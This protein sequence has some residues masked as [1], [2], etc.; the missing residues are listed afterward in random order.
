MIELVEAPRKLATGLAT[1]GGARYRP[2]SSPLGRT[3]DRQR[4]DR[5][6][7]RHP[8]P[9]WRLSLARSGF[10][11]LL[12]SVL[13]HFPDAAPPAGDRVSIFLSRRFGS[14]LLEIELSRPAF[15][16][17]PR[18]AR[19]G[20]RGRCRSRNPL[21]M[22]SEV[23]TRSRRVCCLIGPWVLEQSWRLDNVRDHVRRPKSIHPPRP[24][25]GARSIG[26]ATAATPANR[27]LG[28]SSTPRNAGSARPRTHARS[29]GRRADVLT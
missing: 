13:P 23:L 24:S 28:C 11:G 5:G 29:Q 9:R 16:S 17:A 14:K 26:A 19:S 10:R 7:R 20:R 2:G 8:A 3:Q 25:P 22:H 6:G 27:R 12:R 1:I 21:S 15:P 18:Q 4:D